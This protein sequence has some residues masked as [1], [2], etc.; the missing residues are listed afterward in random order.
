MSDIQTPEPFPGSQYVELSP[1]LAT[2]VADIKSRNIP[3]FAPVVTAPDAS[4]PGT[5]YAL[6]VY[7][8]Y[9]RMILHRIDVEAGMLELHFGVGGRQY[10]PA[11]IFGRIVV[12]AD[13]TAL[14]SFFATQFIN[15]QLD[16]LDLTGW[17]LN[18]LN[19]FYPEVVENAAYADVLR[20]F[21]RD[22]LHIPEFSFQSGQNVVNAH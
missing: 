13:Q 7:D 17:T 12:P 18:K 4:D 11:R 14:L 9:A 10:G 2:I 21:A 8:R 5:A 19:K 6:A 20:V 16:E 1:I 15:K 22:V 3:Y